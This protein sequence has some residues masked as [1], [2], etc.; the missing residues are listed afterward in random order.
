MKLSELIELLNDQAQAAGDAD[1][2]VRIAYQ[3]NYPLAANVAAVTAIVGEENRGRND[4]TIWLAA[5]SGVG[6]YSE[7]PYAPQQAWDGGEV[8]L[9][10]DDEEQA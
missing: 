7:N 10:D 8:A 3:P 1:P 5:S 4:L 2:E 6:S 9:Y